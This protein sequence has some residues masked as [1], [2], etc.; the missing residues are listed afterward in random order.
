MADNEVAIRITAD[1]DTGKA[2]ATAKA[3]AKG[4]G[5]EFEKAGKRG[6]KASDEHSSSLGRLN[7]TLEA[8]SGGI[9]EVSPKIAKALTNPF[10][11]GSAAAATTIG[12]AA[13]AG[14]ALAGFGIGLIG[15]GAIAL[16]ESAQIKAGVASMGEAIKR[17]ATSAAI[18]LEDDL[19]GAMI[20]LEGTAL[21]AG[22]ALRT[23]FAS[24]QPAVGALAGGVDGLVERS[25]PG[26]QDAAEGA[27]SVLVELGSE[28]PELGDMVSGLGSAMGESAEGGG[29]ALIAT[30]EGVE[31]AVGGLSKVMEGAAKG[32]DLWTEANPIL[33]D[34]LGVSDEA[35]KKQT[36]SADKAGSATR[37]LAASEEDAATKAK[38]QAD[39]LEGV[40]EGMTKLGRTTLSA[41]DVERNYQESVDNATESVK[42]NGKTLDANTAKGRANQSALD[43]IANA[44]LR[45]ATAD[46][47]A[48]ASQNSLNGTMSRGRQAFINAAQAMGMS[49]AKARAL[50]DAL[51]LIP[52]NIHINV[53]TGISGAI[54]SIR[55][56][57]GRLNA[58]MSAAG[59]AN[60]PIIGAKASGG[61]SNGLTWTGEQGPEL[62]DLPPG[63]R[64]HSNPDS[65][66]MVADS[67]R[68]NAG[69]AFRPLVVQGDALV[70]ALVRTLAGEVRKQ[71][72]Q[73]GVLGLKAS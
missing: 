58:G 7:K 22:P 66:R 23:M 60:G 62:L 8:V 2:A 72:G 50:A 10:V 29:K 3:T 53:T 68:G 46:A 26:L 38:E 12:L 35:I 47:R 39:A 69:A 73:L 49:A 11:L 32:F 48:G 45:K 5:D 42:K 37:E 59:G 67:M 30:L 6:T 41:R 18:P 40:I 27:N 33:A 44:T 56:A 15:V 51:G 21:H 61:A 19:V 36:E 52:R 55:R 34:A 71:G 64:V 54:D 20:K 57:Q 13:G 65:R 9:I 14:A 17:T 43:G 28:L 31:F 63:T 16:K 70:E 24:V 25:L 1:D 4:I